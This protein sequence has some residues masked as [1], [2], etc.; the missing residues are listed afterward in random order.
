MLEIV[1]TGLFNGSIHVLRMSVRVTVRR[2]TQEFMKIEGIRTKWSS[3]VWNN[4]ESP[5]SRFIFDRYE[6]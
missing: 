1:L 3:I 5:M 4:I 6:K 2:L